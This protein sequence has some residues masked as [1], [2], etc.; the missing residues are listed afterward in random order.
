LIAKW[1]W[2]T[3]WRA[4]AGESHPEHDVVEP[5]LEQPEQVLAGHAGT[6]LSRLE[7]APELAFEDAV[8]APD[9]LLLAQLDAVLG[10][11]AAPDVV[12][13]RRG[14]AALEG[15]LAGIAAVSLEEQLHAFTPAQATH[16]TVVTSHGGGP[17]RGA[18][19]AGGNRCGGWA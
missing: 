1:P 13:A 10:H 9:L 3:S 8:G 2:L 16:G 14:R 6:L 17:R 4:A 19:W 7:V 15:A 12:L 18:A 5:G 11:L